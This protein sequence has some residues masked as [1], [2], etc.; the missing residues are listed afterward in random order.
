VRVSFELIEVLDDDPLTF[1]LSPS[2]RG[3]ATEDQSDS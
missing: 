2:A 1:I 3:E